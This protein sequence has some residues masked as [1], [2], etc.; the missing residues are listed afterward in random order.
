MNTPLHRRPATWAAATLALVLLAAWAQPGTPRTAVQQ[1]AD[2][3][4]NALTPAQKKALMPLAAQWHTLDGTSRD[5]WIN[6]P[7]AS[8]ACRPLTSTACRTA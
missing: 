5:K 1:P 7:T 4:W 8:P 3:S 2:S 6:E